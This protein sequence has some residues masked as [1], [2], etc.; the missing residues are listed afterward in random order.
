MGYQRILP[1][2]GGGGAGG[3]YNMA[4]DYSGGAINARSRMGQGSTTT[5]E[6]ADK[7]VGGGMMAAM[8]G[9]GGGAGIAMALSLSNPYTAA[10]VAGGAALSTL[11][12]YLG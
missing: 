5:T 10:A 7:T 9:A 2:V 6:P 12:Y 3:F 11:A 8:G 1:R 4:K